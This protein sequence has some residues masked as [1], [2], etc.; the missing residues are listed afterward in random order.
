[1]AFFSTHFLFQPVLKR[2]NAPIRRKWRW[3]KVF[4]EFMWLDTTDETK[5]TALKGT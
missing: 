1:V 4:G 3:L 2:R 5:Q